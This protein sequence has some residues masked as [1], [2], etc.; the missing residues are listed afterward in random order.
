MKTPFI[1][2]AES[3][4]PILDVK[5]TELAIKYCKDVFETQLAE[6]LQLM[7]VSAPLFVSKDTGLNDTLNGVEKA[8]VFDI[9]DL[10]QQKAEIIHSLAKRKRMALYKY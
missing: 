5:S 6:K 3:Y 7:R 10:P 9:K 8:I 2:V 4:H 1:H